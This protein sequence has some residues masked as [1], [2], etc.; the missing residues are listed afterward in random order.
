M[1]V[2]ITTLSEN[3]ASVPGLLAEWGFS[4]FVEIDG[5]N[6]LL[7]SG[8]STSAVHNAGIL[9][10]DLRKVDRLIL[11]HGHYD[12]T[13]GLQD[14]LQRMRKKV[15]IIAHPDVWAE[16]YTRQPDN[17]YRYIGIPFQ[18]QALES[19]GASFML[20]RE[21]VRLTDNVLTTG[22]VP[23]ITEYEQI[24]PDRFSVKENGEMKPDLLADDLALVINTRQGLI[25]ILGCGHRGLIN[26]LLH[27]QKITARKEIRLVIGG[28]HLIGASTERVW[29]TLNA[30]KE[31]DVQRIGVSHCTGLPAAAIMAQELGDRFFFNN[32]GTRLVLE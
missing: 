22:E 11:S 27:A 25:I 21:P 8:L 12:H 15:E 10:I 31:M 24:E 16:K 32:A 26:T 17:T 4:A 30:L 13:G 7:D 9:G 1:A 29:M 23:E 6:I 5:L 3:T 20:S 28:C 14:V 19:L 2:K 18:R